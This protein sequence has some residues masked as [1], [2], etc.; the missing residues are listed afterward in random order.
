LVE[1]AFKHGAGENRY[2]SFIRIKLKQEE[3]DFR[4]FIENSF[5]S[6]KAASDQHRIGL[7]NIRRQLELLYKEYHLD[8]NCQ[9]NIF[10]VNLY[11]NL[12][13]YGKN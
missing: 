11:L 12:H 6:P 1:N 3:G 2:D 7:N 10:G 8:V 4:F 13:S 5:E 9:E